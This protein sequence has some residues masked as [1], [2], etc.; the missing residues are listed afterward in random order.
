M[1][2][3]IRVGIKPSRG[4]GRAMCARHLSLLSAGKFTAFER[5]E[6]SHRPGKRSQMTGLRS[7]FYGEIDWDFL[8]AEYVEVARNRRKESESEP[9]SLEERLLVEKAEIFRAITKDTD[10]LFAFDMLQADFSEEFFEVWGMID[11][12]NIRRKA[13]ISNFLGVANVQPFD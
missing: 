13:I 7:R 4:R 5:G 6:L 1:S 9:R 11:D 2:K 10:H 8:T 3:S 12:F